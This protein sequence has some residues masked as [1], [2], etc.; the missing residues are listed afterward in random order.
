MIQIKKLSLRGQG[1]AKR[2]K[3]LPWKHKDLRSDAWDPQWYPTVIPVLR[4]R[5]LQIPAAHRQA[6][7]AKLM[8]SRFSKTP[9]LQ[10]TKEKWRK[11][12]DIDLEPPQR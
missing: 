10:K 1:V 2:A 3:C 6:S 12:V 9:C 7:L 11:S 8:I 5:D 4:T